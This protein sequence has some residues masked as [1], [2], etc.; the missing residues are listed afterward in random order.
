MKRHLFLAVAA[1][2]SLSACGGKKA[3]S[4]GIPA[5]KKE[6]MDRFLAGTLDPSYTP[7]FFFGHFPGANKMGDAAVQAHLSLF[8][9]GGADMLKVQTEQGMPKIDDLTMDTPLVPEDFYRPTLEI[10]RKI[11]SGKSIRSWGVTSM[12]CQLS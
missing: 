11:H 12:S 3:V 1:I 9:Q 8:L 7:A 5:D 10:I 2:L 6:V 4:D